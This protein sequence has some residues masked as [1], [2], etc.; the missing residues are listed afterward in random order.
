MKNIHHV[1]IDIKRVIGS[2]W[3]WFHI[4][5]VIF[6]VYLFFVALAPIKV[7][8]TEPLS[9]SKEAGDNIVITKKTSPYGYAP[10]GAYSTWM[11]ITINEQN[12]WCNCR[13]PTCP[14][15]TPSKNVLSILDIYVVNNQYCLVTKIQLD[16]ES[17]YGSIDISSYT[18]KRDLINDLT[19]MGPIEKYSMFKFYLFIYILC[20]YLIINIMLLKRMIKP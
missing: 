6:F 15:Y 14:T 13:L 20:P 4:V 9:F 3:L 19:N 17:A 7:K 5:A 16:P 10:R 2:R 8:S 1:H 11:Q 12:Y 18:H